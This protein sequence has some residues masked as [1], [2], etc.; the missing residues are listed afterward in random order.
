MQYV[1][2]FYRYVL[3]EL[4][5]PPISTLS[6]PRRIYECRQYIRLYW[7]FA[8]Q[9]INIIKSGLRMV[10][11]LQRIFIGA[12]GALDLTLFDKKLSTF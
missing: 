12:H 8:L 1:L 7:E 2:I 5:F 11:I 3:L 4:K 6:S 10:P 9:Y